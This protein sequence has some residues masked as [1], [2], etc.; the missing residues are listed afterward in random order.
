MHSFCQ[1]HLS[2]TQTTDT[3][4]KQLKTHI[5]SLLLEKYRLYDFI[6]ESLVTLAEA[7]S[8]G[9]PSFD[10]IKTAMTVAYLRFH[11]GGAA[12]FHWPLMLTQWGPNHVFLFFPMAE[13]KFC[14][15][16]AMAQRI[17]MPLSHDHEVGEVRHRMLSCCDTLVKSRHS[18]WNNEIMK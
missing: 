11:K 7:Y 10:Q 3:F 6:D 15:R 12:N 14:Q 9:H 5:L 1:H 16:G 18:R 2:W 13:N 17:N 4:K 8:W